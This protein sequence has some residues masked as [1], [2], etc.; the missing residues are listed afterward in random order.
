MM[1]VHNITVN[2]LRETTKRY[3]K[4]VLNCMFLL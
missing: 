4:I 1:A 3:Q 2:H